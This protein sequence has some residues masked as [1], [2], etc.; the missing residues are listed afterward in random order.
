MNTFDMTWV[1]SGPTFLE[2]P[3]PVGQAGSNP[4]GSFI[5]ELSSQL[6]SF[7]PSLIGAIVVL[8]LGWL[9]ATIAASVIKGF[10]NRTSLDDRIA[11]AVLGQDQGTD[12][13]VEQWI[14]ATVY[15]VILTFTI[16]AFLQALNLEVVSSP[17]NNFLQQ[18]FQYIPRVGG[19]LVLL[20]I[21][22]ALA[23]VVKLLITRVLSRFNL[24]DQLAQQV[25]S[26]GGSPFLVNE[27]I[28]DILY[29]FIF[30]LF[31]P[32]ILS[33]LSLPGLL[34]PVEGLIDQFLTAIPKILTAALVL[35]VGWLVAK[36]VRGI[37]S[38]FLIAAGADQLGAR[39]GLSANTEQG[40]VLSSLVGNIVYALVL[41]PVAIV[42][43][44]ELDLQAISDPAVNMLE[45]VL[46]V[47]PQILLAGVIVAI[48][49]IAGKFIADL[50][51]GLLTGV[52][53]DNL[54]AMLGLPNLGG[55]SSAA[56]DPSEDAMP[57]TTVQTPGKTPSEVVGVI[58]QVGIVLFGIITATEILGFAQLTDIVRSIM[59]V[60]AQV[61][62]GAVVFAIGLYAANLAFR[63]IQSTGSGQAQV[64]AQAARIAI[65]ILVGAMA[66][67]QIGVATDIVNLAF[68]LL[69][70]A[71]AVA[72]AIAFGLGG[73][74]VA[75]EQIREWLE[76]FKRR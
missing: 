34:T 75:S 69:L 22:W 59:Q 14:S 62:S 6:G 19:A 36:I 71:V 55:T 7:L 48:A 21:A 38:N 2:P 37:V 15:W 51:T 35:G 10:L 70:G 57:S 8:I 11:N 33:A 53:F 9:V 68:G 56:S 5:G 32:L 76:A 41:I 65:I 49:Y 29:W 20:G 72:I 30:L 26:Q 54:F 63:A 25:D 16:V 23:T 18:I 13:P 40:V 24:D 42:A 47:I 3:L 50:V 43:L 61:L 67:R 1:G 52:G 64:L 44:N 73:R 60:S 58:V 27:T 28:G 46:E 17:L 39:M 12:V 31:L 66:L 4:M 74:D 45:R